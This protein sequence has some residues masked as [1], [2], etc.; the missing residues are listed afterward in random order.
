[1]KI[2]NNQPASAPVASS[3]EQSPTREQS[4]RVEEVRRRL[5]E[6]HGPRYWRSLEELAG[7]EDF[8]QLVEKEF[9][10]YAP[11]EWE[12]GVSRRNFLALAGASLGLAGLTACTRQP[13]ERIVPY[14][15]QP[16][17]LV[18]GVPTYYATGMTLAGYARGIIAE[19]H[20]GRP[21]KVTG[22]DEHP[23]N[24]GGLDLWGQA[25][26]LTL[27]DPDRSQSIEK[28]GRILPWDTFLE[29]M[30]N[31]LRAVEALGGE[32]LRIL[33]GTQTSP[34]FAALIERVRQRFPQARWVQYETDS[35]DHALA[36]A[37][38][39]F[40]EA[41][42]TRYD[43]TRAD[44]VLSLDSDFLVFGPGAL[45]YAR[46]FAS[47]RKVRSENPEMSRFY[48]LETTPTSTGSMAD[49]RMPARPA[50]IGRFAAA[51]AARVGV[52]GVSGAEPADT[53]MAEWLDA[54]RPHRSRAS[55]AGARHQRRAGQRRGDGEL[56]R[57][58]SPRARS[59]GRGSAPAGGGHERRQRQRPSRDGHQPCLRRPGRSR[60]R[61]RTRKGRPEG[62]PRPL[63]G[64]D[65]DPLRLARA[66]GPLPRRLG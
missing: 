52:P 57:P 23:A 1:V 11:Q 30:Q 63:Q 43:L 47:R 17:H 31:P 26:T 55:G 16:E 37:R 46:D 13:E 21:T 53:A 66:A 49:H 51:L 27:Y 59:A 10:R 56:Q 8:Q 64:R 65:R 54:R 35:G 38:T 18:P 15:E 60:L 24:L 50:E 62:P 5:A 9:P 32:G 39:A 48:A 36:A 34:T 3:D 29:E 19:S 45:R 4:I 7:S 6:E 12:D 25:S 58:G 28:Q 2:L 44:V 33:T 42:E 22:N 41:V 20:M 61:D 40:G 14:V